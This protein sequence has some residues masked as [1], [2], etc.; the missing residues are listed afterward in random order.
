MKN[1]LKKLVLFGFASVILSS[2]V[3][4]NLIANAAC[5]V[6]VGK[7]ISAVNNDANACISK[8]DKAAKVTTIIEEP[9]STDPEQ[10]GTKEEFEVRSCLR[11]SGSCKD[12][13][14]ALQSPSAFIKGNS[15]PAGV[16]CGKISTGPGDWSIYCKEVMALL[17]TGGPTMIKGF[18]SMI[19]KWSASIVG[20]IA[21][22]VIVIS[23]IQISASGGDSGKIDEAKGR[24]LKS[25]G[26]LAVLF[27]S[28]IILYTINP[29]FFTAP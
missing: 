24:I 15:A 23:G 29:N 7:A 4:P 11:I 8:D 25:I 18:I 14:G 10:F 28:G 19:Y 3:I 20:L 6:D 16:E 5:G 22:L 13:G 17:S 9:L 26:G 1:L 2:I 27:L 12:E 21:V